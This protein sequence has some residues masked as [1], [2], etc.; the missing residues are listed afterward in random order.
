MKG[1]AKLRLLIDACL[2]PAALRQLVETFG[3]AVDAAHVDQLLPPATPDELV[4]ARAIREQR[5]LI[6]A[7]G[8]DF[9][10]LARRRQD[11]TG[12]GIVNDQNTRARQVASIEQLV[13]MLLAHHDRG[14]P[15]AGHIFTLGRSGHVTVRRLP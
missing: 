6:T 8:A 5:L 2:T 1:A 13:A 12:I 15:V 3:P 10:L 9:V 14:A 11:H 7:N 4:L